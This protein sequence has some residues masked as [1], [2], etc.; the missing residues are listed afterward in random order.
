MHE[1]RVGRLYSPTRS[2]WPEVM[3]YNYR[4]GGH[5]LVL[6]LGR[7]TAGEI[8]AVREGAAEFALWEHED[9]LVLLYRFVGRATTLGWGDAPYTI[10]LVPAG[11]RALPPVGDD[12]GPE[13]RALL[14]VLVVDAGNGIIRAMR[15][16]TLDPPFTRTLH[17]VIV[18]QA[19]RP[20]SEATYDAQV[21]LYQARYRNPDD[22]VRVA[23]AR[24]RGGA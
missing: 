23:Q 18:A 21:S 12:L 19:A 9:L 14:Q 22:L 3:Q 15:Q 6:F 8:G 5:E 13:S 4:G 24:T 20:W 16:V 2:R 7:P 1:Y 11:E 10:H 17:E